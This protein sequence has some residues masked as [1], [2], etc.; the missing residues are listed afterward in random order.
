MSISNAKETTPANSVCVI[1]TDIAVHDLLQEASISMI[2]LA[3]KLAS[4]GNDVTLLWVP[5]GG[6]K[7]AE[8]ATKEVEY[9]AAV[10]GIKLEIFR[11]ASENVSEFY[12]P[13]YR[14]FGIYRYL[15]Q[16]TFGSVYFPLEGGLPYYTLLAKETGVYPHRPRLVVVAHSPLQ[17]QEG[18]DRFFL[19]N[20]EQAKIA[21]MEKYSAQEPDRLV[22][23]SAELQKWFRERKWTLPQDCRV[24]PALT[25]SEWLRTGEVAGG[26]II[27][28]P[29][30]LF[31]IASHRFRD[32]MTLFCDMLDEIA[33]QGIDDLRIT[34][35]GEFG[36]ILGEHTGGM[37]VRRGRQWRFPIR[38]RPDLSLPDGIRH[39]GRLGGTAI[40]PNFESATGY[41]VSEC[42]RLGVPFV[43]TAVG[44]NIEHVA[45]D[46]AGK[47]LA[48]PSAASLA[49]TL[50]KQI[51]ERPG[52]VQRWGAQGKEEQWL[53]KSEDAKAAPRKNEP[54]KAGRKTHPLVSVIVTHHDRPQY[55]M[56]AIASV[57]DQDYPNFEVIL[58]DDGSK[59]PESH[60]ALDK[61][62]KEFRRKSW[63]IIRSENKYVGAARN[64]GVRA[65]RGEMVVLLDDDNALYPEALST[66]VHALESSRSDVCMALAKSVFQSNIPGSDRT[67]YL[68]HLPL[69]GCLDLGMLANVFGDTI[70][71]YR[72]DVFDKVGFQMEKRNYR[73]EDWEF[74]VRLTQAGLKLRLIPEFLFWYRI[75]T[76]G[77]YR[78]SHYH[79]NLTPIVEV[80]AKHG[81]KGLEY[82]H[83]IFVSQNVSQ[84]QLD[85]ARSNF[86]YSPS[87]T[88]HFDLAKLDPNAPQA[89][90]L[91][92]KI[93]ATENREDTAVGLL[94]QAG[95]ND[96]GNAAAAAMDEQPDSLTA[97]RLAGA[98]LTADRRLT[99]DELL[100]METWSTDPNVTPISYVEKPDRLLL[101]SKGGT[102]TAAVLAAGCPSSTIS[103]MS[104]VSLSDSASGPAEFL[105][106]LCPMHED[107][108]IA[109]KSALKA[110]KDGTSGWVEVS[111]PFKPTLL[112]AHL[113][114]PS[115]APMNLVLAVR[116]PAT[117]KGG[118]LGC[119]AG[120][121]VRTSVE[122][123]LARR[124]RLGPPPFKR[125][126]RI[127]TDEERR[128]AQLATNYQSDLPLLLFPKELDGGIF[129]RPSTAGPVA[130]VLWG[131]FPAFAREVIATVEVAHDEAPPLD[132]ALALTL[133]SGTLDWRSEGPIKP[134]AFSGWTRIEQKFK[135]HEIKLAVRDLI[136]NSLAVSVAVRLPRGSKP[137]PSNAFFRSLAFSWDQ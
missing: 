39:A 126:A 63:K 50:L 33:S 109:A 114:I 100:V 93:A 27:T 56:Q 96:F 135:L 11:H 51:K 111:A 71:I 23:V 74:F 5:P 79:D 98:S 77:R 3:Q 62:E 120:T 14:S 46:N 86:W 108:V 38:F 18:A 73:V 115:S 44:G 32:G 87:D 7:R 95:G 26:Q 29:R 48:Q 101:E 68:T 15:K 21:F 117:S 130:A 84:Y 122:D 47:C 134:I 52:G 128:S 49:S 136:P 118:A 59:L 124:P 43:A 105:L 65:S 137:S 103:V 76:E 123:R 6:P 66:F 13:E 132:F 9:F 37:F 72:R 69:G 61:L 55:L 64:T 12:G 17:W 2:A 53:D 129:I 36:Q 35:I 60:T 4:A 127:W 40:I 41:C 97:V 83:H 106:L 110:K 45:P 99:G 19:A 119:F 78:T 81:F 113:A 28:R 125:R 131:G 107:P 1:T 133:P 20:T 75:S 116:T 88:R 82:F 24:A 104:M 31:L 42:I 58:V 8:E 16:N 80:M 102:L 85:S 34:V 10:H 70:S 67:S 90:T 92:A 57:K 94:A 54:R 25:P 91:L 112:E 22:C 30:E 121:I 89:I